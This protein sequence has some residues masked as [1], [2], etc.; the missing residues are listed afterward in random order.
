MKRARAFC[1]FF[2]VVDEEVVF[3]SSQFNQG[4]LVVNAA[5]TDTL[6]LLCLQQARVLIFFFRVLSNSIA[7]LKP[8]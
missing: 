8:R 1:S 4:G 7:I 2:R 3:F 5:R 6:C